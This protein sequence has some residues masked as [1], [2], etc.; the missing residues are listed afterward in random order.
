MIC[1]PGPKELWNQLES[2]KVSGMSKTIKN[3]IVKGDR[4][5]DTLSLR[6][7]EKLKGTAKM[8]KTK[9]QKK[10]LKGKKIYFFTIQFQNPS[11]HH[12]SNFCMKRVKNQLNWR[13]T[14]CVYSKSLFC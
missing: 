2:E 10:G 4:S 14:Y 5:L 11:M 8:A 6:F 3:V 9:K 1:T 12:T 7:C 13:T